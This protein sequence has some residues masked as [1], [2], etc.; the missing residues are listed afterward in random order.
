ML[1]VFSSFAFSVMV[2]LVFGLKA[3]I[4]HLMIAAGAIIY[5]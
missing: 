1:S 5:L 2:F 3:L 4:I